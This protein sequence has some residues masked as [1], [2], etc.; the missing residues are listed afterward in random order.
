MQPMYIKYNKRYNTTTY[1]ID[2]TFNTDDEIVLYIKQ[3][4]REHLLDFINNIKD[5][6]EQWTIK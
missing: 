4:N 6:M 1:N 2:D 5:T 3:F